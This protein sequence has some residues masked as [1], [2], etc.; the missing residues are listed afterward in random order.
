MMNVFDLCRLGKL[1]DLQEIVDS[2]PSKMD[3]VNSKDWGGSS[4]LHL[5]CIY[6]NYDIAYYLLQQ[7]ADYNAL[8]GNGRSPSF[9]IHDETQKIRLESFFDVVEESEEAAAQRAIFNQV[10]NASFEGNNDM[11]EKLLSLH[12]EVINSTD[13]SGHSPIMFACMGGH[14]DTTLLLYDKGADLFHQS[15]DG[16]NP[17]SYITDSK[18]LNDIKVYAYWHSPEGIEQIALM[19]KK[20]QEEERARLEAIKASIHH[21]NQAKAID[22]LIRAAQR[23]ISLLEFGEL[24][25]RNSLAVALEHM[26]LHHIEEKNREHQEREDMFFEEEYSIQAA[27]YKRNLDAVN[28]AKQ[29][30]REEAAALAKAKEAELEAQRKEEERLIRLQVEKEAQERMIALQLAR[31]RIA[32]EQQAIEEWEAMDQQREEEY[33]RQYS[34]AKPHRARL[35]RRMR[36]AMRGIAGTSIPYRCVT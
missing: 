20:A 7:G 33:W 23:A 8:D 31:K 34:A 32:A 35:Y 5:A 1:N 12:P 22:Y 29:K 21:S 19:E 2:S 18:K 14:V 13:P 16:R 26:I 27:I 15:K 36:L 24:N 30:A 6:R 17:L 3:V 28:A 11:L 9:Y 10:K 4:L 25:V